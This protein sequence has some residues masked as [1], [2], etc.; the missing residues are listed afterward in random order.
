MQILC[1]AVSVCVRL[2]ARGECRL[3]PHAIMELSNDFERLLPLAVAWA[4]QRERE[5]LAAGVPLDEREMRDAT[6]IGVLLPERVRLLR[7]ARIPM[8]EDDVLG[9]AARLAGFASPLTAGLTLR[10]GI[11]IRNDFW[12]DRALIA[13][14]MTHTHQYERLGGFEPFLRR[15][16]SECLSVGYHNSPL[17]R[18][19]VQRARRLV[20]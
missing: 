18:E 13:H 1:L 16:L 8:P 19:A 11:L 6:A 12:R 20:N 10:Y 4:C 2:C 15:Y 17:E 5:V 14:E 9:E 7:V 3:V